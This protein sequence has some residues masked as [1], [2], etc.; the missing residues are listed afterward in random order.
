MKISFCT[1]GCK[2]NQAET[3]EM[4]RTLLKQG[5][6]VVPFLQKAD[7]AVVRACGVTC[8]ASSTTR[9]MIRQ[10]KKQCALV[11]AIGCLENKNLPEIDCAAKNNDDAVK[12]I[13]FWRKEME[14]GC[15][16]DVKNTPAENLVLGRTRALIKIQTGCNFNCAYCIIPSFRGRSSSLPTKKIISEIRAR[17]KENFREIILTGVN[18]CQYRT[19]KT[20]LAELLKK[21]LRETNIERIRLGSLDPRLITQKLLGLYPHP[22]LMPHWH[23]S[24]QS[25]SD[26]ILKKMNRQYT[27]RKYL[28]I[29]ARTRKIY[30]LFSFTTDIIVGFPGETKND[31]AASC[32]LVRKA[33]FAKV[34]IFPFSPRPG[35]PAAGMQ[36]QID[37]KIKKQ[38]VK[39]LQAIARKTAKKFSRKLIG[40]T[41][42]V[43]FEHKKKKAAYWC[44]YTPEYVRVRYKSARNLYNQIKKIKITSFR[45]A[46]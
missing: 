23:L 22:R 3:D 26:V 21:I 10:A 4:K 35:T 6:V 12:K 33:Q 29:I 34:H 16:D 7:I 5:F 40:R 39:I 24:L 28:D 42:P 15:G 30:P 43:L 14:C 31:F 8:A 37:E 41:R 19:G 1:L 25:G 32:S 2:L 17:E 45:L 36:N 44:G 11:L 27:A 9:E 46:D 13:N 18:I 38:R 20:D